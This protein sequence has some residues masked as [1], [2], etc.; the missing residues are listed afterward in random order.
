MEQVKHQAEYLE[1]ILST[2][3]LYQESLGCDDIYACSNCG[4]PD[5]PV[6][7]RPHYARHL[8]VQAMI[9]KIV[10]WIDI[11]YFPEGSPPVAAE[12]KR[13]EKR[14]GILKYKD[15]QREKE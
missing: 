12:G 7:R 8:S 15:R 13:I 6:A 2:L 1:I 4:R 3:I 11:D 14:E 9:E 10:G 5:V